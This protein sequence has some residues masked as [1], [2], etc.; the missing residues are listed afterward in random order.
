MRTLI[1]YAYFC[2]VMRLLIP[3]NLKTGVTKNTRY[4]MV[5][6]GLGYEGTLDIST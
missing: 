4:E 6:N 1:S 3:D 5:L 2:G